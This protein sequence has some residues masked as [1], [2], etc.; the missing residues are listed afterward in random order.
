MEL[1]TSLGHF[2]AVP[3]IDWSF[4]S[5]ERLCSWG[6]LKSTNS[7]MFEHNDFLSLEAY[8][9]ICIGGY[10]RSLNHSLHSILSGKMLDTMTE[11]RGTP[12]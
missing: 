3:S 5:M 7:F 4:F 6:D 1:V 9:H 10:V 12:F 11:T 2:T 8:T